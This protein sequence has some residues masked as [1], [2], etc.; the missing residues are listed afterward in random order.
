MD[1]YLLQL[2]FA[3]LV[4]AITW[5]AG[6]SPFRHQQKKRHDVDYSAGEALACGIFLGASLLHMLPESSEAFYELGIHYPIA[7]LGAGAIFLFLLWLEHLGAD[8]SNQK[9]G[10]SPTYAWLSTL[11]LSIHSIFAGAALGSAPELST[12]FIIMLAIVAH[13]WAASF[14]LAVKLV[15]VGQSLNAN[16]VAFG[17]FSLAFPLGVLMGSLTI[18][19]HGSIPWLQPTFNAFAAGTFLYLGT[20]HGL[21]RATLINQCCNRRDFNYVI[22]GFTLMAV[23]AIAH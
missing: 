10:H 22:L 20:L 12:V 18:D 4:F 6:V 1:H 7:Y 11:V 21:T 5:I 9:H 23:V 14:A 19:A 8:I 3:C 13:K 2:L 15:Q 16:L 17:L